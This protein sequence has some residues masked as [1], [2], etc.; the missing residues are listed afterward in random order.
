MADGLNVSKVTIYSVLAPSA[1]IDISKLIVYTVLRTRALIPNPYDFLYSLAPD[2]NYTL[3]IKPQ[4][5]LT[6]ETSKSG[7]VLAGQDGTE[8]RLSYNDYPCIIFAW[9]W[10]LLSADEA[11]EIFDL[12]NHPDKACGKLRTF[13]YLHDDGFTY[14]VRFDCNL[15]RKS[16]GLSSYAL[17]GI[18]LKVLGYAS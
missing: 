17:P 13:K 1:G 6:E 12:Y 10:A 4:L 14:V 16:P 5:I 9:D 8:A 11:G 2:Y 18:R 7:Q 3:R 15:T